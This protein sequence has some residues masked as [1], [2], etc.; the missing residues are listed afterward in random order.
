MLIQQ[1]TA[2][3]QVIATAF[4]AVAL[5]VNWRRMRIM[6]V[7]LADGQQSRAMQQLYQVINTLL[8]IRT[9]VD[10][11]LE[12]QGTDESTWSDAAKR[13][14]PV[15]CSRFHLVGILVLNGV[16]P[17]ILFSQAWYYSV[18]ECYRLLTPYL[19]RI[20]RERDPRYWSAFDVIARRVEHHA[21]SF[22]GFGAE[23]SAA[24]DDG[25]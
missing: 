9:D 22:R 2:I 7:Q 1:I 8:D 15:V 13:A 18:P 17:E 14:A 25:A 24:T 23:L 16:V 20:R 11:V 4:V 5:Y 21:K 6:E 19:E 10:A 3:A 12:I